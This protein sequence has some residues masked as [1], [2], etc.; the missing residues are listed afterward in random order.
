MPDI[1]YAVNCCARYMF[2]SKLS[3]E[4]ASK[5][6]DHYLKATQDKG[7]ILN[8]TDELNVDAYPDANFAGL[9]GHKKLTD[10]SCAK[11]RTEL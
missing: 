1:A 3:H 11:S 2:I 5:R 4:K 10:P 6:I 9:Y 8:P 7:L